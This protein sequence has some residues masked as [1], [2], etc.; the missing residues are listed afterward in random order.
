MEVQPYFTIEGTSVIQQPNIVRS[1]PAAPIAVFFFAMGLLGFLALVVSPATT[2]NPFE[3]AATT[4][5]SLFVQLF[6]LALGII[7]SLFTLETTI[8]QATQLVTTS[9]L[10]CVARTP[11]VML[12]SE[13][14]SLCDLKAV[15]IHFVFRGPARVY[16]SGG[17]RRLH[18]G[19]FLMRDKA[20]LRFARELSVLLHL[21]LFQMN[22]D[23]TLKQQLPLA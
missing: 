7:L 23:G 10:L 3:P 13:R 15:G 20:A 14:C 1:R 4:G 22:N 21:P 5:F 18:V 8:D 2:D 6:L 12:R 16:L 9:S 11:G 17:G 19:T